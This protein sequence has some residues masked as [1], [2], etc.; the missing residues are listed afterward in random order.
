MSYLP[1]M[2]A[3]VAGCMLPIQGAINARLGTVMPHPMQATLISYLGGMIAC[4][5]VLLLMHPVI[6]SAKQLMV[7]DYYL[8]LG[9]FLGAVFVASMLYLMPQIGVTNALATAIVGQ[10]IMSVILDHFGALGNPLIEVNSTRL[11]GVLLL[12]LGLFFIQSEEDL[13]ARW[14]RM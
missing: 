11:V 2:L 8:Y 13:V 6:P 9:G 4:V 10:L 7:D 3:L 12:L 1:F 5:L 14:L